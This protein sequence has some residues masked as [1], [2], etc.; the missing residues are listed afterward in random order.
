MHIKYTVYTV[1]SMY[2]M[3][4]IVYAQIMKITIKGKT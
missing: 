4:T 1:M 3:Q 2:I